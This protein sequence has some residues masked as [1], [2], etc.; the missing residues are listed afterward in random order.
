MLTSNWKCRIQEDTKACRK[1]LLEMP[2]N[3]DIFGKYIVKRKCNK[4]TK[5][6]VVTEIER[7]RGDL[8]A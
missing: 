6:Q 3:L 7:N 8:I 4:F 5:T 1:E 2:L